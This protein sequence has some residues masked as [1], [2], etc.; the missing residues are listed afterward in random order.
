MLRI[1]K[2]SIAE[3]FSVEGKKKLMISYSKIQKAIK[4]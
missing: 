2:V 3:I 4:D 1:I